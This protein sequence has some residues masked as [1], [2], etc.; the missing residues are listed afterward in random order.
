MVSVYVL[1]F[2]FGPLIVA[3]LSEMY[4]RLRLYLACNIL[5]VVSTVA[6]AVSTNLNMLIGFRFIVG[7]AARP[8]RS[9]PWARCSAPLLGPVAGGYPSQARGW[10]WVFWLL[11]ITGSAG[12]AAGALIISETH[13]PPAQ[14]DGQPAAALAAG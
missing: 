13:A 1:G 7:G 9:W 11:A 4:G 3:P 14:G 12:T 5:F 8:C 10:R 2:A 6:C